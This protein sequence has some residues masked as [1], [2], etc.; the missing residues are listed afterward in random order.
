LGTKAALL[1]PFSPI[2]VAADE[3][4]QIRLKYYC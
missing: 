4:E 1:M 2:V 3:K